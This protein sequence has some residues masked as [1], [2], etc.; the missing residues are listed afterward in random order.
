[1][2]TDE[3]VVRTA[4][5]AAEGVILDRYKQSELTDFDVTVSFEDD[6]LDVDVYVNPP[7]DAEGDADAVADAA[8]WAAGDAVDELFA[9][10]DAE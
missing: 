3:E 10:A 9:S 8:A 5:S 7:E 2:P 1:M 4:A 6:V